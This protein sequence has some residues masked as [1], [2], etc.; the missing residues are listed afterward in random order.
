[1]VVLY[2]T[3][4]PKCNVL[5]EKLDM[6]KIMYVEVTD[7]DLMLSKGIKSSPVLECDGEMMDF[8]TANSWINNKRG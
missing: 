1:M 5:K 7:V 3:H 2:T 6:A 8:V 4:C